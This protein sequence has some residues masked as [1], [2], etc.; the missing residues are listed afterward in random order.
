[1]RTLPECL[2]TL[3][4]SSQLIEVDEKL[5]D[6]IG[7]AD[8]LRELPNPTEGDAG[9]DLFFRVVENYGRRSSA[10]AMARIASTIMNAREA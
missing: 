4:F 9:G 8:E 3:G 5:L 10:I 7:K 6:G 2:C 1:M